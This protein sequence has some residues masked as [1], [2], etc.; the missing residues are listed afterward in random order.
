VHWFTAAAEARKNF[1]IINIGAFHG[2]RTTY[3]PSLAKLE[4]DAVQVV[5][6]GPVP[7]RNTHGVLLGGFERNGWNIVF[8]CDPDRMHDTSLETF[9]TN[10]G[11]LTVKNPN[12]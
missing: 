5:A 12:L 1:V 3:L 10:D 4:S 8:N 7:E 6:V 9:K 11:V 2:R